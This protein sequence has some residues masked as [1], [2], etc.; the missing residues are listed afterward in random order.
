[1][2]LEKQKIKRTGKPKRP[3]GRMSTVYGALFLAVGILVVSVRNSSAQAKAEADAEHPQTVITEAT[4]VQD[5]EK[6]TAYNEIDTGSKAEGNGAD[7]MPGLSNSDQSEQDW[8]LLL[9]NEAH[10]LPDGYEVTLAEIEGETFNSIEQFDIRAVSELNRM[11]ADA[12]AAGLQIVVCSSYRSEQ[13]QQRLVDE[14]ID[15]YM[16]QGYSYAEA[17][18]MAKQGIQQPGESEHQMGL[19]VDLVS[20]TCPLLDEEQAATEENKWLQENCCKYGFILRYPKEKEAIT[21]ISY[22][23]WHFRY[24]GQAAQEMTASGLTLEE[25][26]GMQ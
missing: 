9:V 11:L 17:E 19:A 18:A 20:E 10:P 22:E 8:S 2:R 4:N 26:L 16:T 5:A 12:K 6:K 21:G 7:E 3:P 25:Y 24:V 13:T 1:M 23:S 15:M 14:D